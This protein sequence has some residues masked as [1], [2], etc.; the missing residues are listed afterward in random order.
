[1]LQLLL[2][3]SCLWP[4]EWAQ[5]V[6]L[7][8]CE[9]VIIR[10]IPNPNLECSEYVY[11]NGDDS[12]YCNGDCSEPVV[13]YD[14]VEEPEQ[15]TEQTTL[16]TTTLLTES[17]ASSSRITELPPSTTP[18]SSS[19]RTTRTTST[20]RTT[21]AGNLQATCKSSAQNGVYPYPANDNY[22][23][24]CLAGYLLLQQCPQHFHFSE[25][26]RQCISSKSYQL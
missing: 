1:M 9:G 14:N 8:E 18:S 16:R 25:A 5:A 6:F 4:L 26:Q 2:A 23:Y 12:Y 7:Q 15:E 24:Q 3:F 20:F 22:Y 21:T 10:R 13:C 11:C 19:T 17:T